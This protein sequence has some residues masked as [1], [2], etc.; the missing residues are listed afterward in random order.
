VSRKVAKSEIAWVKELVGENREHW[1]ETGGA[2]IGRRVSIEKLVGVLR[3][4]KAQVD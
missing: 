4:A 1:D 2:R 3:G